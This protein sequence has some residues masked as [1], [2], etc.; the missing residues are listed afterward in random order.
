MRNAAAAVKGRGREA[1]HVRLRDQ[2]F[3]QLSW[4]LDLQSHRWPLILGL[5]FRT[6]RVGLASGRKFTGRRR[7]AVVLW[8]GKVYD[9]AENEILD[10]DSL[11]HLADRGLI[12]DDYILIV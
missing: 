12:I 4:A 9:P 10:I 1:H 11:G 3:D 8:R 7:H 2:P 5:N 6:G